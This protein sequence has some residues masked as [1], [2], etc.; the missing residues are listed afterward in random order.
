MTIPFEKL[1]LAANTGKI[2]KTPFITLA[3]PHYKHRPYLEQVL[4]S[5]FEQTFEDFEILISDD[6]SPDDSAQ[7]IPLLLQQSG[8][9]FRYYAQPANLGYDGNVRFCL[10]AAQGRYVFMLGNDDAL[11]GPAVLQRVSEELTRLGQ[12]EVAITN[13]SDWETGLV[14]QN[15]PSTCLLGRGPKTAIRFFRSFS[16]IS[17]LIF[18]RVATQRH[19][20][21]RWD[22]SI[23]YQIY[24][25]TRIIAAGG[26]LGALDVCAVRKNVRVDKQTVPNYETKWSGVGWSFQS[27]HTGLDS[28]I[29][30]TADA[31][32]PL[33]PEAERSTALRSMVG[34]ILAITYPAWLFEYRRVANW[35]FAVGIARD[36]WPTKILAEYHIACRDRLY[37]WILYGA[38][39]AASLAIPA[40]LFNNIRPQLADF[41]RRLRQQSSL[42]VDRQKFR[43][44]IM[45]KRI[46]R[47]MLVGDYT[48]GNLECSYRTAFEALG[49][50][51]CSFSMTD[52][53]ARYTRLGLPGRLLNAFI[54]VEPW[55]RKANRDLA[56]KA[57]EV[58]PDALIT[59]GHYP[60][61]VGAL[62]QIKASVDTVLVHI[63]PDTLL[64]WDANL[65]V[66]LP[67]YDLVATYSK[68][69]VPLFQKLGAQ[70]AVWVPLAGDP[71]L[72]PR[73][74]CTA[75]E[76]RSFG[77]EVT[78][79]GGWRPEREMILS[80]LGSYRLAIWGP[81]W[82][83]R[84]RRNP[85]IMGAWRGRAIYGADFSRAIACS[86]INLNI[87]D[88]T[89]YPA[90]NMRFF[91]IPISGGL[92]VASSCPEMEDDFKHGEHVFYYRDVEELPHLLD[93]VLGNDTL[94]QDVS[95]AAYAKALS[96]HTY[97]HRAS[98]ILQY[99]DSSQ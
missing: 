12:P 48:L 35:S 83:Q 81:D 11:A 93:L 2:G 88:P 43:V 34:Q 37:V 41:V 29:R 14:T 52:A 74:A 85:L 16:F 59:F 55:L 47:V 3:I 58:K 64:N 99:M 70:K 89:N 60:I 67:L 28:V 76:Q 5:V 62:A 30:V 38:A 6:C 61:R 77:A 65:T 86:K 45:V 39:T 20:T 19:E 18:S 87:I 23:Y 49:C 21:D 50:D 57:A 22:H 44:I 54:P 69:N 95:A 63:W 26:Q 71:A 9:P 36:L 46:R 53:V 4:A 72:H 8:R 31:I 79:V 40:C 27:R 90:A 10:A 75:A 13:V 98:S 73:M 80:Q 97:T 15:A 82:G 7:T 1:L 24:L 94:Q 91:E 32:L 42:S 56:L 51:V 17:G 84:C 33:L 78:F 68:A 92:Q 96:G 25:A 66:C